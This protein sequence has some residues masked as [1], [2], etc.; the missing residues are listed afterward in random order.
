M[1][2]N[3]NNT[4]GRNI[5][6]QSKDIKKTQNQNYEQKGCDQTKCQQNKPSHI[7]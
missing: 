4:Q 6:Q 1:L 2:Q 3:T 7:E 5:R